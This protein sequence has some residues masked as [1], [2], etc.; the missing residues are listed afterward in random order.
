M[1][2]WFSGLRPLG[3]L[4]FRLIKGNG[5]GNIPGARALCGRVV[6]SGAMGNSCRV[7]VQAGPE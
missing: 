1:Q 7:I 3:S 5:E 2:G 6:M 4:F